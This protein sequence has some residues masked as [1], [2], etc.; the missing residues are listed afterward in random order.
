MDF[1]VSGS[2]GTLSC[3]DGAYRVESEL[4]GNFT[5]PLEAVMV[6]RIVYPTAHL[7]AVDEQISFNAHMSIVLDLGF[8]VR[9]VF[10]H[11]GGHGAFTGSLANGR[12]FRANDA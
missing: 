11:V 8:V 9:P 10:H 5:R 6:T 4:F 7:F 2:H 3:S 1:G 12:F